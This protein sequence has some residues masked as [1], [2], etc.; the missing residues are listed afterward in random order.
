MPFRLTR[1]PLLACTL[2]T[3]LVAQPAGAVSSSMQLPNLGDA[4]SSLFSSQQEYQL[5]RAWL[6]AFRGQAPIISDPLLSDYLEHLVYKLATFSQ[7]TD[8]RLELVVVDNKTLNAFAVPGGVVGVHN[9]MFL[10]AQNED[11]L[12]SVLAHELAHLSQRHFA[13]GMEQQKSSTIINLATLLGALVIAA[14]AGGDAGLAA[15]TASQ[16]AALE[17]QLRYSRQN[18]AEADRVGMI[19]LI[20]AGLDP[21]SMATMFE[22]MQRASRYYGRPPEFLLTHPVTERRIADARSRAAR[23]ARQQHPD[24]LEY[25]LMQ[26][27]VA[28]HFEPNVN[29]AIKRFRSDLSANSEHPDAHRYGLVL[30]LIKAVRFDEAQQQLDE[31]LKKDP[32]RI[33]Y[34]LAQGDIWLGQGKP[35]QARDM[36]ARQ[37]RFNPNNHP[38]TM[39]YFEALLR[40]GDKQAAE[41]L[42]TR[43]SRQR[44]SDPQLW[45]EL[46]EV[47]GLTGDILGVHQARAEYFV[48]MGAPDHAIRQLGYALQT[49]GISRTDAAQ[50]QQRIE[51]IQAWKEALDF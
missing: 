31:L 47:R 40:T 34:L 18:E 12:A 33:T 35:E 38:L 41:Q 27:R 46:A 42:L 5:G 50:I 20:R 7:L 3:C 13:R 16:A 23:Y 14:T 25:R 29:A 49:P 17:N 32:E 9:G 24:D 30:A 43:H 1:R 11:E 45:Y 19:T 37:L 48:L 26:A 15:I 21:M 39:A 22:Q 2:T 44:P 4:S 8:R 6:M 51:D 28:L 10:F 36:L